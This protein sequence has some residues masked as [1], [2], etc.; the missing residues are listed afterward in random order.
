M[1]KDE[2]ITKLANLKKI[3]SEMTLQDEKGNSID[4]AGI[5]EVVAA[6]FNRAI[7]LCIEEVE[8]IDEGSPSNS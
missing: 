4:E 5:K 6:V 8:S 3:A 7:D 2:V 1:N